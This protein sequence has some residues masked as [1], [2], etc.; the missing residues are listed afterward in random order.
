MGSQSSTSLSVLRFA[1]NVN[2][3]VPSLEVLLL[4]VYNTKSIKNR[5]ICITP[6]GHSIMFTF[7]S[8]INIGRVKC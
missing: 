7:T 8:Q 2:K 3:Q 5:R 4:T 6:V 1:G